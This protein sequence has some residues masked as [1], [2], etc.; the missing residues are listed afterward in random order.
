MKRSLLALA[1]LGAL[2]TAA[3]AQVTLYG[4]IDAGIRNKTNTNAAGD[5]VRTMSSNGTYG[6][7]RFGFKGVEDLGGGMNAHF[8]LESGF[9][10]GTGGLDTATNVM[11]RRTSSVGIAGAWGAVDLGR[12]YTIAFNTIA[13]YDPMNYKYVSIALAIPATSGVWFNNDIRY[14]GTFGAVTTRAEYA[15]GEVAGST[16]V[17]STQAIGAS[18]ANGPL[19]LGAAYTQKKPGTVLANVDYK[20]YTLGGAYTF[21]PAKISLGY[22]NEK[23]PVAGAPDNANKYLWTG[24]AYTVSP[25]VAVTGAWYQLKNSAGTTAVPTTGKKDLFMLSATY[26]LSKRTILYAETDNTKLTG[27]QITVGQDHQ[28][29]LSV[30]VNHTF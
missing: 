30:G 20:H 26:A 2:T 29:G 22:V 5:S 11:W 17:G 21:G 10:T 8:T 1:V 14:T 13:A 4:V 24:V 19:A 3:Q 18:Y 9:N 25:A 28:L 16:S 27:N 7:N 15:L 12:Q 6:S 23:T